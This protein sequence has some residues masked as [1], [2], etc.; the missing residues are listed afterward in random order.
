MKKVIREFFK[1]SRPTGG[2]DTKEDADLFWSEFERQQQEAFGFNDSASF[3]T[4][5]VAVGW[6]SP[7][8]IT[9]TTTSTSVNVTALTNPPGTVNLAVGQPV[10]GTGIVAGTTI[11]S[12]VSA[13]AITLSI[14][15]TASG[16]PSLTFGAYNPQ[17]SL[18]AYGAG[19][20]Y[21]FPPATSVP[22]VGSAFDVPEVEIL[23]TTVTWVPAP[24]R[25]I[26]TIAGGTTTAPVVQ[27]NINGSWVTVFTGTISATVALYLMCDGTNVRVNNLS[28]TATTF[29]FYRELS[30]KS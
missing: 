24:G 23:P 27:Y 7:M 20:F 5:A 18:Y 30:S 14:A 1:S 29:T 10:S 13:T 6:I 26:M 21:A 3:G 15:A 8:V 16:S 22:T 17:Q 12:I 4:L 9:G 25:G 11:A 2:F 19:S 28:A